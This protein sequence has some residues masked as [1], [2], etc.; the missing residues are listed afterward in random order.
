MRR[1]E[2]FGPHR[3]EDRRLPIDCLVEPEQVSSTDFQ[4]QQR[5]MLEIVTA[6]ARENQKG[7]QASQRLYQEL[8]KI[9]EMLTKKCEDD[10]ARFHQIN[11]E[12]SSVKSQIPL[13]SVD[14]GPPSYD[15]AK[16]QQVGSDDDEEFLPTDWSRI[17]V[18]QEKGKQCSTETFKE[19][20][21]SSETLRQ[22]SFSDSFFDFLL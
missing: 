19:I 10:D 15:I 22:D 8:K 3:E 21:S 17:Q 16:E 13:N 7:F 18:R 4:E 6:L 11:S 2:A 12:I 1:A 9:S 14:S 20:A 5:Y